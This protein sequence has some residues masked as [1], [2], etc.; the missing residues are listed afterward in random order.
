M[1]IPYLESLFVTVTSGILLVTAGIS[2]WRW[3]FPNPDKNQLNTVLSDSVVLM[4]L[5]NC[6]VS[7]RLTGWSIALFAPM[8]LVLPVEFKV[9]RFSAGILCLMPF[10]LLWFGC[11]NPLFAPAFVWASYM[12]A[13]IYGV[14]EQANL[15]AVNV[16]ATHEIE[17]GTDANEKGSQR[18]LRDPVAKLQSK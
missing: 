9:Y 18:S 8:A 14:G 2:I 10:S 17:N 13:R 7:A 16:N 12:V 1:N 4:A 3:L 5:Y 6:P 11:T 15:L